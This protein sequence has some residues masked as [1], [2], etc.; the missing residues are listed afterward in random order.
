MKLNHIKINDPIHSA[1]YTP[2]LSFI[3]YSEGFFKFLQQCLLV[4]L[5]EEPGGQVTELTE[6]QQSRT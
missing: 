2:F 6:L 1:Q 4:L 5:L 3:V